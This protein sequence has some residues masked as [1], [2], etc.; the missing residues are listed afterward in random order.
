MFESYINK[1]SK[2]AHSDRDD[3][4]SMF[5]KQ[6][7]YSF[8]KY[9]LLLIR[10]CKDLFLLEKYRYIMHLNFHVINKTAFNDFYIYSV[11]L[12]INKH[13]IVASKYLL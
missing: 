6:Y 9:D 12:Y 7:F 10:I 3:F 13:Q 11:R 2:I 5:T 8:Y 1:Y 4:F